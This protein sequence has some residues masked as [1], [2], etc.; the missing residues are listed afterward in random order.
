MNNGIV[1][2]L[3]IASGNDCEVV[4]DEFVVGLW[5]MGIE[6]NRKWGYD[7]NIPSYIAIGN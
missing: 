7:W 6:P 4:G 1:T 2:D 3:K 5:L